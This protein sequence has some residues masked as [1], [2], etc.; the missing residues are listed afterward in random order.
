MTSI[1]AYVAG[2]RVNLVTFCDVPL[3]CRLIIEWRFVSRIKP[4][5][6]AILEGFNEIVPLPLLKIFDE[7]ELELLMCGL[8]NIDVKNWK[9]NT[10]Y[11]GDYHANHMVIQWFWRVREGKVEE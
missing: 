3:P 6:N 9:Q 10:V 5:M 4:Q 7:N 2:W 1:T 11:K 8:G